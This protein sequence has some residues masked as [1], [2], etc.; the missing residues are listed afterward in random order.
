V[1]L[2]HLTGVK[3]KVVFKLPQVKAHYCREAMHTPS[4]S[5]DRDTDILNECQ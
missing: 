1:D 5:R 3:G 4:I 2:F